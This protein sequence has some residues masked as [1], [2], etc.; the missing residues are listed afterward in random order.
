MTVPL[1]NTT[2]AAV[3]DIPQE[4]RLAGLWLEN[5]AVDDI[6]K[7]LGRTPGAVT[8]RACL[9]GLGKRQRGLGASTWTPSGSMPKGRY[10]EDD[11][12]AVA[13][14]DRAPAVIRGDVTAALM[15]DPQPRRSG[16]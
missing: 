13:E 9:L 7:A 2:A 10:F 6:A 4:I 8:V 14:F 15:G 16:P 1:H 5:V 12:R 3:W 11:P